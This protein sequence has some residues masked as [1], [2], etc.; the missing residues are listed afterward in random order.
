MT[1]FLLIT[2][3]APL[4]SFGEQAGNARRGSAE[5]PTKSG[6]IGLLGAALGVRRADQA[7]QRALASG[8][9]L[10]TR[11]W[12][13][14]GVMQDFHTFQSLP[15]NRQA[16]TRADAL[17]Q[18]EHLETTLSTREYREDVLYEAAFVAETGAHWPLTALRDALLAPR[19]VL[20][21]GR[22]SCPIAWPLFPQIM[23]EETVDAAFDT[24]AEKRR[25]LA[26][27]SG[28]SHLEPL[29]RRRSRPRIIAYEDGAE[30]RRGNASTRRHRRYDQPGDRVRWHFEPR[31]ERVFTLGDAE[32]E[33]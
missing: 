9:A 30:P 6:L 10:A 2:L 25:A 31:Q 21:L 4:A 12:R 32:D 23:S 3:A 5:R 26:E 13:P 33:R 11:T 20:S 7:G 22:K 27:K 16:E 19:F 24:Y 8:Y 1:E 28:A 17:R 15:R 29:L 14:G 18:K